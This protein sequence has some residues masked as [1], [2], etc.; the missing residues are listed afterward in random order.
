VLV[1]VV[2]RGRR[3]TREMPDGSA[4]GVETVAPG[5]TRVAKLAVLLPGLPENL[6]AEALVV[7]VVAGEVAVGLQADSRVTALEEELFPVAH[8]GAQ[9][10][11]LKKC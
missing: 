2:V 6:D 7:G 11:S 8:R 1:V 10:S 9:A 3:I 4:A 5:D